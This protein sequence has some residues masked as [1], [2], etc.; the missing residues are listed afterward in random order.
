M[1]VDWMICNNKKILYADFSGLLA[2]Q[3]VDLAN[4]LFAEVEKSPGKV[5]ILSNYQNTSISTKFVEV[6]TDWA[7]KLRPKTDRYA[8]YGLNAPKRIMLNAFNSVTSMGI[9]AFETRDEALQYLTQ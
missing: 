3:M 6:S 9:K 8:V 2:P 7:K 4:H 1:K 5:T